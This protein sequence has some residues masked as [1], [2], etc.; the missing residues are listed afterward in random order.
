MS[1]TTSERLT[2][3]ATSLPVARTLNVPEPASII[4]VSGL[5]VEHD[6]RA[7]GGQQLDRVARGAS[8]GRSPS[9]RG[10]ATGDDA[11]PRVV[12]RVRQRAGRALRPVVG[13]LREVEEVV[14]HARLGGRVGD[15]ARLVVR[16]R[17]E[18]AL[19]G[20]QRGD[21]QQRDAE[22]HGHDRDHREAALVAG[23]GDQTTHVVLRL[24]IWLVNV[25]TTPERLPCAVKLDVDE[26]D[27]RQVD[28]RQRR[29]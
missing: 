12:D 1:V 26:R 10:S 29:A 27:A 19:R 14:L 22:H 11:V 7:V 16:A 23:A 15:L 28:G 17:L 9:V 24:K 2:P 6:R 8:P 18:V 20:R 25:V 5:G 21:R 4:V 3:V 13:V